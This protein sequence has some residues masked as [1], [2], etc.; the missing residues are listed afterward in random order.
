MRYKSTISDT[1]DA[2][3]QVA[4]PRLAVRRLTLTNFRN[5][6]T[7]R[8]EGIEAPLVALTG[9]NGAG[10]TNVLEALSLLAPGRGLRRAAFADMAN[11]SAPEQWAA[12]FSLVGLAGAVDV[13]MAWRAS[14]RAANDE[15][16]DSPG[17]RTLKI[18]GK[19]ARSARD[20]AR[21]VR[22]AWLTPAMDG[23]FT[24]PASERRRFIDRLT[25]AVNPEHAARITALEKLLRQRNR[26]LEHHRTQG[27]WLEAIEAQLA[28]VAV[29]V[30]AARLMTVQAIAGGMRL[31]EAAHGAFPPAHLAMQGW[32]EERLLSSP[33]VEVE[34]AYRAHLAHSRTEDAAAGRTLVGAH[35]SDLVV[36]HAER[37]MPAKLCSTGEQKALL[38]ALVLA[39]AQAVKDALGGAAPILLLDEVAAHL[40]ATRR[41]GLFDALL[42]LGAQVWMTG[43]DAAIFADLAGAATF[44][45]IEDG[46]VRNG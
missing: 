35:R 24:G 18:D 45:V 42:A 6:A 14:P 1:S 15:A 21:H 11:I 44:F 40:D 22:L 12:A 26:L 33:A 29:A 20:L 9:P 37:G 43:T 32:L 16:A 46:Q 36:T 31:L 38:M 30:A 28:E 23:L 25:L 34:D 19:Q 3:W 8:I 39:H 7:T 27:A 17:S 13:G 2:P 41:Q 5:H 4:L 10:K